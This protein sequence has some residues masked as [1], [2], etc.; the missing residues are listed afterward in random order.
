[1]AGAAPSQGAPRLREQARH[2]QGERQRLVAFSFFSLFRAV[3]R[4]SRF[5]LVAVLPIPQ[6]VIF[7]VGNQ[8]LDPHVSLPQFYFQDYS[9][10]CF[11]DCKQTLY[12]EA[13]ANA[14]EC[15][16]NPGFMMEECKF[17]CKACPGMD[18]GKNSLYGTGGNLRGE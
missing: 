8:T 15:K 3:S 4:R 2:V 12:D 13:W 11:Y 6:Y 17:A 5:E 1:M 16:K 14:G 10:F 9:T 18:P 7:F